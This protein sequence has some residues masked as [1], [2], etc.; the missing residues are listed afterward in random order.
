MAPSEC[1]T[2]TVRAAGHSAATSRARSTTDRTGPRGRPPCPARST[3]ATSQPRDSSSGPTRHQ[4][5]WL[6]DIPWI[7]STLRWWVTQAP[8]HSV[9]RAWPVPARRGSAVG[10]ARRPASGDAPYSGGTR[11]GL[12]ATRS[13]HAL[14]SGSE[15][16]RRR[17]PHAQDVH[18]S[19]SRASEL[20]YGRRRAEP[21]LLGV[22]VAGRLDVPGQRRPEAGEP[23]PDRL[24]GDR[25]RPPDRDAAAGIFRPSAAQFTT[26][27]VVRDARPT[28]RRRSIRPRSTVSMWP[29]RTTFS[30][31]RSSS[32]SHVAEGGRLG[33]RRR[34]R[35]GRC[36]A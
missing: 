36:A 31:V 29:R 11:A 33:H 12:S 1:P 8:D 30:M 3:V 21:V 20:P 5:L 19:P 14:M 6:D 18:P 28:R 32:S 7:S 15:P 23:G 24:Q 22:V 4:V 27:G 34:D 25:L 13:D 2:T 16:K 35:C 17:V 9:L 26:S 10:P